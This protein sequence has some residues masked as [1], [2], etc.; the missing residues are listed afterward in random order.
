MV[1]SPI[2]RC[3]QRQYRVR[4]QDI[5][6]IWCDC[7]INL[8]TT[9]SLCDCAT[10]CILCCKAR[11]CL[12]VTPKKN[13]SGSIRMHIHEKTVDFHFWNWD[14]DYWS[15]QHA[16]KSCEALW[17]LN[18]RKFELKGF[19]STWWAKHVDVACSPYAISLSAPRASTSA[20]LVHPFLPF[21]ELTITVEGLGFPSIMRVACP[22][23]TLLTESAM[24]L[25]WSL[26]CLDQ[27]ATEQFPSRMVRL[28]SHHLVPPYFTHV[29]TL[30]EMTVR[31][32]HRHA[33]RRGH[34]CC[35][36]ARWCLLPPPIN[37]TFCPIMTKLWQGSIMHQ[38]T[39][40]G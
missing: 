39:T 28:L 36:L 24:M 4:F 26:S 18:P 33:R 12:L 8:Q 30:V 13:Q 40:L 7:W 21:G 5:L 35:T 11:A 10:S 19:F 6:K 20:I 37:D 17:C 1:W 16:K 29:V 34:L 23:C 31:H 27:H 32:G 2:S 14:I 9:N 15:L 3:V 22:L 25:G 38:R